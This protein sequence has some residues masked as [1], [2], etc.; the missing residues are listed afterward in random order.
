[1]KQSCLNAASSADPAA[2]EA[3]ELSVGEVAAETFG[4]EEESHQT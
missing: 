4:Q 2:A 3:D 1:M